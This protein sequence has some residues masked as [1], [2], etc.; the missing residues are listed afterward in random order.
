LLLSSRFLERL[1]KEKNDVSPAQ[2][3][4]EFFSPFSEY[5]F[6]LSPGLRESSFRIYWNNLR[7]KR[8]L[9]GT[10]FQR[11]ILMGEMTALV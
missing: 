10:Y 4:K 5:P 2:L 8:N 6:P 7:K 3:K 1:V 11:Q 9:H